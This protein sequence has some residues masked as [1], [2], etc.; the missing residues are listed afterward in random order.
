MRFDQSQ[1]ISPANLFI[2]AVYTHA[3]AV[4]AIAANLTGYEAATFYLG[5]GPAGITLTA[6]N[7]IEW[8]MQHSDDNV[9]FANVALADV[10]GVSAVT[11]GIV[12]AYVTAKAAT[13]IEE[14]GYVGRK[15]FVTAIPVFGGSHSTGTSAFGL[16]VRGRPLKA[17]AA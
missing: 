12:R 6:T 15:P 2:P 1:L 14:I 5:L 17:P 13:T 8:L 3:A 10:T 7:K 16:A 9:T 11:D 4:T